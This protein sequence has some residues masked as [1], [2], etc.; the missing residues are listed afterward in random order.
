MTEEETKAKAAEEEKAAKKAARKARR[1]KKKKMGPDSDVDDEL[2]LLQKL[3]RERREKQ[4][5]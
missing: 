4:G 3:A 5:G 2:E 1:K